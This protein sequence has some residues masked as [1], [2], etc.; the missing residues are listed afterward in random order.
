MSTVTSVTAGTA[1]ETNNNNNNDNNANNT[2]ERM[3][4]LATQR[5]TNHQHQPSS[6]CTSQ[7]PRRT[8]DISLVKAGYLCVKSS[9]AE[10]LED[11]D[12]FFAALQY[13]GKSQS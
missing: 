3:Q 10:D 11:V 6:A 2:N 9:T 1:F 5:S 13:C 12:E 7:S 4:E 8:S